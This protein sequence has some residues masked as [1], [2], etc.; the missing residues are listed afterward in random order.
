[1]SFGGNHTQTTFGG[2]NKFLGS[3]NPVQGSAPSQAPSFNPNAMSFGGG[4][5]GQARTFGNIGQQS[6]N[7]FPTQSS[8]NSM[9]G[10]PTQNNTGK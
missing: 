6:N 7:L 2:S 4:S 8:S 3:Q 5:S 9:F 1:M 10:Q